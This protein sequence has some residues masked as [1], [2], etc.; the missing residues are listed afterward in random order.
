MRIGGQPAGTP[1]VPAEILQGLLV[2]PAFEERPGVDARRG[3]PLEV[4]LVAQEAVAPAVK[5]M[6][7]AHLEQGCGGRVRGD[8]AANPVVFPVSS[9]HHRHGVP[10]DDAL[11]AAFDFAVA[12]VRVLLVHGNRVDVGCIGA[13]GDDDLRTVRPLFD[14]LEQ[15][16]HPVRPVVFQGVVERLDPVLRLGGVDVS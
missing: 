4:H 14:L 7:E 12:R 1:E 16:A 5:E 15:E 2:D 6:V 9:H 11:D 10:A 8:V 13:E 3:V